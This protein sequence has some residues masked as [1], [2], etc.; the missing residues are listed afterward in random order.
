MVSALM[1]PRIEVCALVQLA[2]EIAFRYLPQR[3]QLLVRQ[4]ER[5]QPFGRTVENMLHGVQH[6]LAELYAVHQ[7]HTPPAVLAEQASLLKAEKPCAFLAASAAAGQ[8]GIIPRQRHQPQLKGRFHQRLGLFQLIQ[9]IE[10]VEAQ[11]QQLRAGLILVGDAGEQL[12]EIRSQGQKLNI[13]PEAHKHL[14]R[15][16]LIHRIKAVFLKQRQLAV[17]QQLAPAAQPAVFPPDAPGLDSDT[18]HVP[19]EHVQQL[20]VVFILGLPQDQTLCGIKHRF[21]M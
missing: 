9:G 3:L 8:L 11:R 12:C 7:R 4:G 21:C 10:T 20:I 6:P 18:P 13:R 14:Q 1:C 16:R 2:D 5:K 15:L 19:G 17:A